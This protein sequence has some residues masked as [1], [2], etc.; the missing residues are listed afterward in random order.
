MTDHIEPEDG[1]QLI[2]ARDVP[3]VLNP[4]SLWTPYYLAGGLVSSIDVSTPEGQARHMQALF[5]GGASIQ[6][7]MN[8]E[9]EILDVVMIGKESLDKESGEVKSY[10]GITLCLA[11]G[12]TLFTGSAGVFLS[13]TEY[14][15]FRPQLPWNP[16]LRVVVKN[17]V[18]KGGKNFFVLMPAPLTVV[19]GEK[20]GRK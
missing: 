15:R 12:T 14:L 10:V 17:R 1:G 9:I 11:D 7:A 6:E 2:P 4:A 5:G 13:L 16:P 3:I 19:N 18:G 8:S 20:K